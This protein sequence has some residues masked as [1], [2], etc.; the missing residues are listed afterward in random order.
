MPQLDW[1]SDLDQ[2]AKQNVTFRSNPNGPADDIGA[3][4]NSEDIRFNKVT[5]NDGKRHLDVAVNVGGRQAHYV[6]D[7]DQIEALRGFLSG[8]EST[9]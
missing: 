1:T 7:R 5:D 6:L 3:P 4:R 2:A 9:R 8:P